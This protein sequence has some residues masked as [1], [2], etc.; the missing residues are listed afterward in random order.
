MCNA[1]AVRP[2]HGPRTPALDF[3]ATPCTAPLWPESITTKTSTTT[4]ATRTAAR[5]A[6]A[7]VW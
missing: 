5:R 7:A 3:P 2:E 4:T 1:P 6:G